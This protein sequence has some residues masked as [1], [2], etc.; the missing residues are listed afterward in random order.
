MDPESSLSGTDTL[1]SNR[2]PETSE[3]TDVVRIS[4]VIGIKYSPERGRYAIAL[5]DVT[6]GECILCEDPYA[7]VVTEPYME[8]VCF[9]C[10]KLCVNSTIFALSATDPI[11]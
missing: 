8:V 4:D 2:S 7:H 9:Y 3:S 6:A 11:R 10:C 5:R 1:A